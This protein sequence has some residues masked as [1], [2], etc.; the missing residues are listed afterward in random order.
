MIEE[1]DIV[2][3][4]TTTIESV[5]LSSVD[6]GHSITDCPH[7]ALT[8]QLSSN[9]IFLNNGPTLVQDSTQPV[10]ANIV[11]DS[12]TNTTTIPTVSPGET[13]EDNSSFICTN[14]STPLPLDI[15]SID[16]SSPLPTGAAADCDIDS[17]DSV[18]CPASYSDVEYSG[19]IKYSSDS[20]CRLDSAAS[21]AG[22]NSSYGSSSLYSGYIHC[23]TT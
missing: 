17:P 22:Y 9:I 10:H 13:S 5:C 14:R 8:P 6:S 23:N 3:T 18:F 1:P 7:S 20:I 2:S 12:H 15:T 21:D 4:T 11:S 16:N 19:S